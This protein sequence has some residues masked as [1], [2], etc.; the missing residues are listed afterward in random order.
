M[1]GKE[2][3][4]VGIVMTDT[5]DRLCDEKYKECCEREKPM[6]DKTKIC[7]CCGNTWEDSFFCSACSNKYIGMREVEV[8]IIPWDGW[9]PDT[10]MGEEEEY[11]GDVCLNCCECHFRPDPLHIR[12]DDDPHP[13]KDEIE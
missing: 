2:Q 1:G 12:I 4:M 6:R 11:S 5:F 9:G 8:P 13:T 10:E 3:T 7:D